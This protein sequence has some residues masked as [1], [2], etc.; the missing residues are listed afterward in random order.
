MSANDSST[1]S[2]LNRTG[3]HS[4][5]NEQWKSQYGTQYVSGTQTLYLIADKVGA[6][7]K[8]SEA[9]PAC[10]NTNEP[11]P[12]ITDFGIIDLYQSTGDSETLVAYP[13]NFSKFS[14]CDGS[15]FELPQNIVVNVTE[16]TGLQNLTNYDQLPWVKFNGTPPFHI[17][18]G[19]AT[20]ISSGSKIQISIH[21]IIIVIVCNT[22]KLC[23]MLWTIRRSLF[24]Q[25][26]TIGDAICS[27]LKK[28][29]AGSNGMCTLHRKVAIR[30]TTPTKTYEPYY[31]SYTDISGE[32]H[33]PLR[34]TM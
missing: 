6:K 4:L 21:F 17:T 28:P 1:I 13:L 14:N 11:P 16:T 10:L 24:F 30:R 25:I 29:Y 27:F 33:V 23:A 32:R 26:V 5:T 34:T 19:F 3:A 20:P 9:K 8:I 2:W 12:N 15:T 31:G 18:N 7:L 22:I